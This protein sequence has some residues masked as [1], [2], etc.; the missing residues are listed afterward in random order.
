MT[1]RNLKSAY[2]TLSE[3]KNTED[4]VKIDLNILDVYSKLD[5][6]KILKE[7]GNKKSDQYEA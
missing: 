2:T 1:Y 4:G 5:T 6:T 7:S 3:F